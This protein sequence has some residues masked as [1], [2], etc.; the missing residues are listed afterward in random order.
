MTS[1]VLLEDAVRFLPGPQADLDNDGVGDVCDDDI[2][3]DDNLN[4]ADNCPQVMNSDQVDTD[5]DGVGDACNDAFDRDGDQWSDDED[6]CPSTP[7]PA[8]L[9]EDGDGFGDLC[10]KL[11]IRGTVSYED[12]PYGPG[13]FTGEVEIVAASHLAIELVRT[14]DDTVIASGV[15]DSLGF[16]SI[17][18]ERPAGAHYLRALAVSPAASR[19]VVVRDRSAERVVYS[20]RGEDFIPDS[21]STINVDL[22][23]SSGTAAG[24]AFNILHSAMRAFDLIRRHTDELAPQLVYRWQPLRQFDCGSCYSGNVISLGGQA[25]DPDEYD[26]DIILHEFGHYFSDRFS[27]DSSPGGSHNGDKTEPTL[28]YGEGFATFFS[29]MVKQEPTYID[30]YDDSHKYKNIETANEDVEEYYGTEAQ[31]LDGDVSEYLVAALLWDSFDSES[32]E[33]PHDTLEIGESG[34]MALLGDWMRDPNV[35]DIG[36]EGVDLAD[37]MNALACFAPESNDALMSLAQ[38]RVYPWSTEETDCTQKALGYQQIS[39]TRIGNV[40][41]LLPGSKHGLPNKV[42]VKLVV[43]GNRYRWVERCGKEYCDV[44]IPKGPGGSLDDATLSISDVHGLARGSWAGEG[45]LRAALGGMAGLRSRYGNVREYR[46][47]K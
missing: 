1:L 14:T 40:L 42:E 41:R 34:V 26:D 33:E 17:D 39:I 35:A 12:M 43:G 46:S 45:A 20:V 24:G 44:R 4:L 18:L 23:A 10:V 22:I 31:A 27:R 15:V 11:N 7:N 30:N 16:Y 47:G 2:D 38:E 19:A 36:Y 9:D 28:A 29:S 3:G 6:N 21:M 13:G 37:W 8:Q 32:L 25:S 5:G